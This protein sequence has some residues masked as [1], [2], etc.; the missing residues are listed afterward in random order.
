MVIAISLGARCRR[1]LSRSAQPAAVKSRAVESGPPET[2]RIRPRR[3]WRPSNNA[4]ASSS[5]SASSAMAT[6]LFSIHRLLYVGG[7]MRIFAQNFA[8][9]RTGGFLLAQSG[10]RLAEPQQGLGRA[11]R[12]LVFG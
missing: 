1:C 9:R 5:R 2:A 12:R 6:L 8:E 10:Q 7:S 3:F 4:F 11:R